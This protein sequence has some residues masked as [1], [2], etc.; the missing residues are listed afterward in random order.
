MGVT[1]V[2]TAKIVGILFIV[3]N[4]LVAIGIVKDGN[5][6]TVEHED[7]FFI[8]MDAD[9]LIESGGISLPSHFIKTVTDSFYQPDIAR[10]T[11]YQ[12]IS[13]WEEGHA[14]QLHDRFIG[15][16]IRDGDC[17]HGIG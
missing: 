5:L 13:I 16:V 11:R 3:I 12:S 1:S 4:F 9:R 8:D 7:S 17:V 15:V 14:G 2:E 6:T 10:Q